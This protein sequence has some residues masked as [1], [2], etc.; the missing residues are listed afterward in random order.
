ME[1]RVIRYAKCPKCGSPSVKSGNIVYNLA[2]GKKVKKQRYTC[3]NT[4]CNYHF[5]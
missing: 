3:K 1:T 5:T 2:N 4:R